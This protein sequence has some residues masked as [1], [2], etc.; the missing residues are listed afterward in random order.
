VEHGIQTVAAGGQLTVNVPSSAVM[1]VYPHS[2]V[3]QPPVPT[4]WQPS[5]GFLIQPASALLLSASA[6]DPELDPIS[7]AWSITSTPPGASTVLD[8]PMSASTNA[9]GLTTPGDYVFTVTISDPT[10]SVTREARVTVFSQNQPPVANDVHNRNPVLITLPQSSTTLRAGSW[11]MENDARDYQWRVVSQP[12]GAA[13]SLA[14]PGTASCVASN[15]TVAG[16]YV[17]EVAVSD[18]T[19]TVTRQL[20]V[21][22]YP[23]NTAPVITLAAQPLR[24]FQPV[25][26]ATLFLPTR[27]PDGD[28]ITHWWSLKSAPTGTAPV[29]DHPGLPGTMVQGLNLPGTYVFTLTVIDRSLTTTGDLSVVV[30][31]LPSFD[32]LLASFGHTT[33]EPAYSTAT[34][35]DGDGI[36]GV[37]DYQMWL[38]YYRQV[39]GD[40]QASAPTEQLGD[41]QRDGHVDQVDLD[42]L[43][44]CQSGPGIPPANAG[45]EDGDLDR[46]GDVDQVDFGCFQRC[47]TGADSPL[48][49][50]CKY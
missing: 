33:G 15:M 19:H 46:D 28:V 16:D 50:S 34:D 13:A 25:S 35:F 9:S 14:T 4:S 20:T 23:V 49:L 32:A 22:V 18:P 6:S 8:A 30:A 10:H 47:L 3:N 11:D 36:I 31:Q 43:I 38:E 42:H 40:P 24:V 21:P 12:D 26:S 7:F 27:D 17:F 37:S 45:C 2:G 39:V 29:I 1:T 48:D 44:E 41:F 5:T